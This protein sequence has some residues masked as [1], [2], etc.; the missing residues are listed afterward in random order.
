MESTPKDNTTELLRRTATGDK[1]AFRQLYE[2]T[3]PRLYSVAI[4]LMTDPRLAEDVLQDA[5][6]Q[7]WHRAKDYHADRGSVFTWLSS[8]VRYRGIDALRKGG[9]YGLLGREQPIN[10]DPVDLDYLEV[11]A[12][13]E[14]H[15]AGPLT[16]A[17]A[18]EDTSHLRGCIDRL[19]ANQRRSISLAFFRGFTH[20]ELADCLK[21]PLGTVKSRLRRSLKRLRECLEQLYNGDE[22]QR[23]TN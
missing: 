10:I 2:H 19:S 21:E 4:Q 17:I 11:D 13:D 22:V 1:Q 23:G 18:N 14:G 20:R 15:P 12:T 7:I 5:F 8:I 9:R 16:M 3:S 6:V